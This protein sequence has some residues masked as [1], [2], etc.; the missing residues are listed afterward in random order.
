MPKPNRHAQFYRSFRDA[1]L[2]F[3]NL[4]HLFDPGSNIVITW[5][6]ILAGFSILSLLFLLAYL[7]IH[8]AL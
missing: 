5:Y 8:F 3:S 1:R 7:A 6:E 4:R 2:A